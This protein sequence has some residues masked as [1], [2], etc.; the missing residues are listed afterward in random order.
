MRHKVGW[1]GDVR[2]A[3]A[4]EFAILTPIFLLML[5]GTLAYGIYFSAAHSL[6]QLAADAARASIPGLNHIERN[7]LVRQFLDGHAE[8]YLLIA[9]SRLTFSIRDKPADP[10]QYHVTLRYDANHLPIWNLYP[11][12]PHPGRFIVTTSTIGPP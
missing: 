5:A 12:L 4:V 11:P 10:P 3:S 1:L 9:R 2:G 6:E 7:R 8:T